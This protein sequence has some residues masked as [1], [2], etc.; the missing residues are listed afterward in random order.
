M[1]RLKRE[2]QGWGPGVLA[3]EKVKTTTE[4]VGGGGRGQLGGC[5]R[6]CREGAEASAAEAGGGITELG[7]TPGEQLTWG[8]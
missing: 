1:K 7:G 8:H 6:I 3:L 5:G 2:E 4:T